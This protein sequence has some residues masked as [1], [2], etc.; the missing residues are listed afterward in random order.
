MFWPPLNTNTKFQVTEKQ[1]KALETP[2][3]VD[4]FLK[5]MTSIYGHRAIVDTQLKHVPEAYKRYNDYN[6]TYFQTPEQI[7]HELTDSS[8]LQRICEH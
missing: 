1:H 7:K 5:I 8:G 2:W 3:R 6:N 4:I